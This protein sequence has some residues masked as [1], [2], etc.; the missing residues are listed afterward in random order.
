[1]ARATQ[2]DKRDN[3]VAT[4]AATISDVYGGLGRSNRP[5]RKDFRPSP[6]SCYGDRSIVAAALHVTYSGSGGGWGPKPRQP[7]AI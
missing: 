5:F 3:G 6:H 4:G 2:W 1:M 7:P